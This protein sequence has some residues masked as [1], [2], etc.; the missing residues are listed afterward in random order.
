MAKSITIFT[1]YGTGLSVEAVAMHYHDYNENKQ[2][3]TYD[4]PFEFYHLTPS[5]PRYVMSYHWHIEFELIRVVSGTL[6]VTLD[7][8]EFTA[9]AGEYVFIQSGTLHSG[10]PEDCLYDCIVFDLNALL[11]HN[12]LCRPYIQRVI[13]G[14]ALVFCHLK[15]S[16]GQLLAILD[17]LFDAFASRPD[18]YE[19]TVFGAFYRFFGE[20]FARR[21][22]LENVPANHRA[23]KKILQMK[24]VLEYIESNY[25]SPITLEQLS[26]AASMTPKYFCRFFLEMTH[27]TPIDYLNYQ[28]IEHA[29]YQLVTTDKSVTD[30]AYSCGFNDL[31]YF[32]KTFRKYKGMTPG[33]YAGRKF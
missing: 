21:R 18:G 32:I 24:H 27:K 13:D 15:E 19:L 9:H 6:R 12:A 16:H 10:V 14:S 7:T 30:I 17:E 31:S 3:G 33:K 26:G 2:R 28:R 11:K 23:Y 25:A 29:C 20:V 4:F 8:R 5:H 1:F 22:Y